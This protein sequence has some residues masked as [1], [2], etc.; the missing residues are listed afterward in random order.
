MFMRRNDSSSSLS[1]HLT[2]A[3]EVQRIDSAK[4]I[5]PVEEGHLVQQEIAH[6]QAN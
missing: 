4:L 6:T 2:S 1:I 5:P 3:N